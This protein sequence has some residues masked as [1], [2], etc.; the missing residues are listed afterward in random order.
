MT[1]RAAKAADARRIAQIHVEARRAAY[2]GQIS[3]AVLDALTLERRMTFWQERLKQAK[4]L[5]LVAEDDVVIG[6]CDL[7]PSRDKDAGP[8]KVAEI[9]AI[10][11]LP[12]HWRKGTGRALC[13][14]ALTEAR[15]SGYDAV[16][17]WVL[18]SN[19]DAKGFYEA[20][21]FHPDG[22]VKTEPMADGSRLNEMRFRINLF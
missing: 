15:Q 9:V 18:A 14:A 19:R 6:F 4:G 7:I 5:V 10:Y 20:I 1:I 2:R 3:N 21:G 11:I 8:R 16:M 12:G 13:D 22:G 17:L